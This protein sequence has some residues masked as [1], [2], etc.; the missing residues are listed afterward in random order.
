MISS[1]PL[2]KWFMPGGMILLPYYQG[3]QMMRHSGGPMAG[4]NSNRHS[5]EPNVQGLILSKSKFKTRIWMLTRD[6]QTQDQEISIVC[7]LGIQLRVCDSDT[8]S[9][10]SLEPQLIWRP[11]L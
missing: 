10:T 2:A 3:E 9:N 8:I 4:I 7:G 5:A 6:L 11:A 1:T